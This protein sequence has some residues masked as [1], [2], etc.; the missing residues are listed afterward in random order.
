[1]RTPGGDG[2]APFVPASEVSDELPAF[3][4]EDGDTELPVAAE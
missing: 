3:L 2:N 1:M 4:G